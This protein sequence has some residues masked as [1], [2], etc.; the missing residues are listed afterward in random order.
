[1]TRPTTYVLADTGWPGIN[2][3][4]LASNVAFSSV[5]SAGASVRLPPNALCV[6]NAVLGARPRFPLDCLPPLRPLGPLPPRLPSAVF[7]RVLLDATSAA[8]DSG[9]AASVARV[10]FPPPDCEPP[11][12]RPPR[13]REGLPLRGGLFWPLCVPFGWAGAAWESAIV[14]KCTDWYGC[15]ADVLIRTSLTYSPLALGPNEFTRLCA[16]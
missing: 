13:F 9:A 16:F 7:S 3:G 4:A 10:R 1:M 8:A 6:P 11:R 12:G 2:T 14:S 5:S 15:K